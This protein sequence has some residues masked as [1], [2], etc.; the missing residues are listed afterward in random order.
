M[1]H[2]ARQHSAAL[3]G[4]RNG[5]MPRIKQRQLGI[6]G[7]AALTRQ[8]PAVGVMLWVEQLRRGV[9]QLAGGALH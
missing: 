3:N 7:D 8:A 4:C 5:G 6:A 9:I 2:F 1:Q